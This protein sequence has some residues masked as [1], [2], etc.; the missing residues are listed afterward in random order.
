VRRST[1]SRITLRTTVRSGIVPS[2]PYMAARP[3][4]AAPAVTLPA[5]ADRSARNVSTTSA[6]TGVTRRCRLGG[7][8]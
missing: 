5:A 4:G 6:W 3:A 2:M 8:C 1:K 7:F